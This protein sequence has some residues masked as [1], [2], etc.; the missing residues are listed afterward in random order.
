MLPGASPCHGIPYTLPGESGG[1]KT[2]QSVVKP[3]SAA[4]YGG[5]Y[6]TVYVCVHVC[7]YV[8]VCVY[9]CVCVYVCVCVLQDLEAICQAA[10]Q[11]M[12]SKHFKKL[13]EVELIL[14]S[15]A[16]RIL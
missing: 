6:R 3:V 14:V 9:M 1:D 12:K 5:R 11:L 7:V 16:I 2:G 10:V 4:I 15:H 8:C 13:L